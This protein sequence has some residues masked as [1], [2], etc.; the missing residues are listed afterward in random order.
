[1]GKSKATQQD[2]LFA[3]LEALMER[4]GGRIGPRA[5]LDE[6]RDPASPLHDHIEWDDEK[7]SDQ[8]RLI[9][10]GQLIRRWKG[11]LVR[12]EEEDKR[13]AYKTVRSAQSPSGQRAKGRDSYQTVEAIMADPEKRDDMISTVLRE[14]MAYRKRY[15]ELVALAGIWQAIDDAVDLHGD[16]SKSKSKGKGD[17]PTA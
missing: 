1:M 17:R 11:S 9:Q 15:S 8:F 7:A 16:S 12:V 3:A 13:A 5:V 4:H 6:A 14:L 2:I 10:A